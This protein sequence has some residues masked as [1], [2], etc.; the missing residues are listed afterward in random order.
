MS[1]LLVAKIVIPF[2]LAYAGVCLL[3]FLMQD[4]L[5]FARHLAVHNLPDRLSLKY[6]DEMTLDVAPGVALHGYYSPN[7]DE[8]A[9]LIIAFGGNADSAAEL[10]KNLEWQFPKHRVAVF[11][12]RG[13][14]KST[15]EPSQKALYADALTVHDNLVAQFKPAYV[16]LVGHSLGSGMAVYLSAMRKLAGML[17]VTPYDS[18]ARVAQQAYPFLPVMLLMKHRFPSYKYM[19]GNGTPTQIIVAGRDSL[20]RPER[21]RALR[22]ITRNLVGYTEI[23]DVGHNEIRMSPLYEEAF[24]KALLTLTPTSEGHK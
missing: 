14:G 16:V 24:Q 1:A 3:M 5:I 6:L 4:R 7:R 22:D 13:Y 8:G 20:V 10:A 11:D 12:Y 18:L 17:L 9:P 19:V 23:P 2:I 15:G 21:G